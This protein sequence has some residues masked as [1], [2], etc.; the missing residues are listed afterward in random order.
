MSAEALREVLAFSAT[1]FVILLGFTTYWLR[2][3]ARQLKG[4]LEKKLA[5][6]ERASAENAQRIEDLETI[7]V[8]QARSTLKESERSELDRDVR[9]AASRPH[10]VVDREGIDR[11]R[12]A[13][14]ARRLRG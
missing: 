11:Q 8:S 12:A 10:E 3:R 13:E 1:T 14:L 6:L 9:L 5:R 2:M 4:D 7:I